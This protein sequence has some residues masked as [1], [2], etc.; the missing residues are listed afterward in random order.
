MFVFSRLGSAYEPLDTL[1]LLVAL[2][3]AAALARRAMTDRAWVSA[4]VVALATLGLLWTLG[5]AWIVLEHGRA[6]ALGAPFALLA[7]WVLSRRLMG[8]NAATIG[9]AMV[10]LLLLL[11]AAPVLL[12]KVIPI[13]ED[14]S[15]VAVVENPSGG[16]TAAIVQQGEATRVVLRPVRITLARLFDY[17]ERTVYVP[18]FGT[19][20][21]DLRW[22]TPTRLLVELYGSGEIESEDAAPT[23][24]QVVPTREL[25]DTVPGASRRVREETRESPRPMA[26]P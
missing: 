13:E 5:R 17:P 12:G 18:G 6:P 16:Y 2:G 1:L 22:E 7:G 4:T 9:G 24:I 23:G 15:D 25:P 26:E 14:V 8:G 21:A 11:G 10:A 20:A 3:F 19:D